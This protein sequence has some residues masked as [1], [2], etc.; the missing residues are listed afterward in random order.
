[1]RSPRR[2]T[3][4]HVCRCYSWGG[5]GLQVG[6]DEANSH[7]APPTPTPD[8]PIRA[9]LR[10]CSGL[11][12]STPPEG[13]MGTMHPMSQWGLSCCPR[14]VHRHSCNADWPPSPTPHH[15]YGAAPHPLSSSRLCIF[16]PLCLHRFDS[17]FSPSRAHTILAT[18]LSFARTLTAA[19][20]VDIATLPL[21]GIA[22]SHHARPSLHPTCASALQAVLSFNQPRSLVAV[23]ICAP[24]HLSLK[25][26][27][28]WSRHLRVLR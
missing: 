11:S 16:L 15:P 17:H 1:M 8:W 25:F 18:R 23:F 22:A 27:E 9:P 7:T 10:R 6:M 20:E 24:E 21:L 5:L 12:S 13:C 3:N 26:L 4:R 28:C 19:I 2:K 14:P